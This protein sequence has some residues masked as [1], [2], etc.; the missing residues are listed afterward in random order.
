MCYIPERWNL[1]QRF[2]LSDC[3]TSCNE[4][5]AGSCSFISPDPHPDDCWLHALTFTHIV[6][7]S[8]FSWCISSSVHGLLDTSWYIFY[9]HLSGLTRIPSPLLDSVREKQRVN[10]RVQNW[11]I[12]K[13]KA[14]VDAE[15]RKLEKA[16]ADEAAGGGGG[17]AGEA[18]RS[19]RRKLL[20]EAGD[21]KSDKQ[22]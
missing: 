18:S 7:A 20:D 10:K 9:P 15:R 19:V 4:K 11:K 17:G 21:R 8:S 2:N 6:E 22:Q 3:C 14:K 13:L 16:E 12:N 1:S 5:H